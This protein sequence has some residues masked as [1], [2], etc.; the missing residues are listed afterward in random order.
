[1][2]HPPDIDSMYV[3]QL[4]QTTFIVENP[5]HLEIAEFLATLDT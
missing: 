4:Q 3:F 2:Y 5:A 1:M